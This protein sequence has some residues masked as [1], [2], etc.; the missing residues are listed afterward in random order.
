MSNNFLGKGLKYPFS[1]SP[2]TGGV[3]VSTSVS[4][5]IKHIREAILQLLFTPVGSRFFRPE[6]GSKLLELVFEQNDDV[7]KG[8]VKYYIV[9]AIRKW[10]KRVIVDS[11]DIKLYQDYENHI[12]WIQI[13]FYV[14]QH[15]VVGNLVFPFYRG[16][17]V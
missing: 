1:F 2:N 7:L 17:T 13:Q 6:Y 9:D 5:D 4:S 8:L 3:G 16:V 11:K 15:N 14:I 12:L 10:E